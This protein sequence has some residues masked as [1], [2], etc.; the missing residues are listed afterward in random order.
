MFDA[1]LLRQINQQLARVLIDLS[2]ERAIR[3]ATVPSVALADCLF[4]IDQCSAKISTART[5]L[6]LA[7]A[8]VEQAKMLIGSH[9]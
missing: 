7:I 9:G 5:A 6:Q 4:G 2:D 3:A 8:A 1:V